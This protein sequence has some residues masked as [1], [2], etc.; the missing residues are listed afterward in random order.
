MNN[1]INDVLKNVNLQLQH[2]GIEKK[3]FFSLEQITATLLLAQQVE[4]IADKLDAIQINSFTEI[5]K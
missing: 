1:V 2:R 3:H 4:R 5:K